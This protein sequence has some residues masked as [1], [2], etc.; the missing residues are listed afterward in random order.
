MKGL[1][2]MQVNR[3]DCGGH[4]HDAPDELAD[5]EAPPSLL[6]FI[7]KEHQTTNSSLNSNSSVAPKRGS[8]RANALVGNVSSKRSVAAAPSSHQPQSSRALALS[9]RSLSIPGYNR[10]SS[11]IDS[12]GKQQSHET[13]S[14]GSV[15]DARDCDQKARPSHQLLRKNSITSQA[16]VHSQSRLNMF[17]QIKSNQAQQKNRNRQRNV[18]RS[19]QNRQQTNHILH[20]TSSNLSTGGASDCVNYADNT[21]IYSEFSHNSS[22]CGDQDSKMSDDTF[23]HSTNSDDNNTFEDLHQSIACRKDLQ[24]R[25]S[26]SSGGR[27]LLSMVQGSCPPPQATSSTATSSSDLTSHFN[28]G[29]TSIVTADI[30][31]TAVDMTSPPSLQS[32]PRL[33]PPD[34][35]RGSGRMDFSSPP[36][37][38]SSSWSSIPPTNTSGSVCEPERS[39]G[40]VCE[41][42]VCEKAGTEGFE[43]IRSSNDSKVSDTLMLATSS[44]P[45]PVMSS[46]RR[47]DSAVNNMCS[48]LQSTHSVHNT[49]DSAVHS[50]YRGSAQKAE[51]DLTAASLKSPVISLLDPPVSLS[52]PQAIVDILS[53]PPLPH[54]PERAP[55]VVSRRIKSAED[56]IRPCP[57]LSSSMCFA[58][59]GRVTSVV[60]A[61]DGSFIVVGFASGMVKIYELNFGVSRGQVGSAGCSIDLEDRYGHLLGT[62]ATSSVSGTF[63]VHIEMGACVSVGCGGVSESWCDKVQSAGKVMSRQ[64]DIFSAHVF[65]GARLG[66][67]KLIVADLLSLQRLKQKRGFITLGKPAVHAAFLTHSV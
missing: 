16:P 11:L 10:D 27:S 51:N 12:R 56:V 49:S 52:V 5:V 14:S 8:K 65:A 25:S 43:M 59:E 62:V 41:K 40:P 31:D 30:I 55:E 23:M 2:H 1:E 44:F 35:G 38:R 28:S 4:T 15:S 22:F 6:T 47:M 53:P 32:V 46:S 36:R 58:L 9:S 42:V 66:T 24:Q 19:L 48:P 45:S 13:S 29:S 50:N 61:R 67:T 60:A 18:Q 63:R 7:K 34:M 3:N 17:Q 33:V 37:R 21:F 54:R 39:P 57:V 26:S 20:D 64:E